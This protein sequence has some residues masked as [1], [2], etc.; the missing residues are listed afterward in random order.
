MKKSRK[1]S[2]ALFGAVV[3]I[4]T[5]AVSNSSTQDLSS[6]NEVWAVISQDPI[7]D[8]NSSKA[9]QIQ[10][11][12]ALYG[13]KES[14]T[15]PQLSSREEVQKSIINLGMWLAARL[16]T[17]SNVDYRE[18]FKKLVHANGICFQGTWNITE[19]SPYSG[20]FRTGT[21]API[22]GRVS[23]ASPQTMNDKN[24][25]FGFAG[26]IFPTTNPDEKVRTANFFTVHNLNGTAVNQFLDVTLTNEPPVDLSGSINPLA[27]NFN[28]IRGLDKIFGFVDVNPNIRPLYPISRAKETAMADVKTPIWMRI[29]LEDQNAQDGI[30]QTDFRE[31][32]LDYE[33]LTFA[34]EVSDTTK[35]ALIDPENQTD[36]K[37][38]GQIKTQPMVVSFG[39]DRR[40][41]FPHPKFTPPATL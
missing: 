9:E 14:P 4:S 5:V 28:P 37:K 16:T 36:W 7:V 13:T 22:I 8:P 41:H 24:R 20:L 32:L 31:E 12:L 30:N 10:Q 1:I 39:C 23:A 21:L 19:D 17:R 26:K 38:L 29:R 34:I 15:L 35:D 40:L 27:D 6:F 25:S 3:L 33:T 2:I 18:Y 11:D